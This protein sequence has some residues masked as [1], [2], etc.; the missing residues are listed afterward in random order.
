MGGAVRGKFVMLKV[1]VGMGGRIGGSPIVP[2][3]EEVRI[4]LVAAFFL[5]GELTPLLISNGDGG[6]VGPGEGSCVP[7]APPPSES[8]S[9]RVGRLGFL[10]CLAVRVP[11]VP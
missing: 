11:R 2:A 7:P 8:G 1:F 9:G 4:R 10:T 3:A 6:G 5:S